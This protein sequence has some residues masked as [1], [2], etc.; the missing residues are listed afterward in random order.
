MKRKIV[1]FI[2][3]GAIVFS[4]ASFTDV[5]HL[6]SDSILALDPTNSEAVIAA[7]VKPLN[8]DSVFTLDA[9]SS[10][11]LVAQIAADVTIQSEAESPITV[12]QSKEIGDIIESSHTS[13]RIS[14]SSF[15]DPVYCKNIKEITSP[16]PVLRLSAPA[17][18]GMTIVSIVHSRSSE[19]N[20]PR[21]EVYRSPSYTTKDHKVTTSLKPG[22]YIWSS[23]VTSATG[24]IIKSDVY[25][26][27][28]I[29]TSAEIQ[30]EE[31]RIDTVATPPTITN[32]LSLPDL[33][34]SGR[35]LYWSFDVIEGVW[36]RISKSLHDAILSG[37]KLT[38][39]DIKTTGNLPTLYAEDGSRYYIFD[40]KT[41][42]WKSSTNPFK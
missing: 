13:D 17:S 26:C 4:T 14:I 35:G 42:T 16:N 32:P 22:R 40:Y 6:S 2:I 31:A 18:G 10:E 23:V 28:D 12:E 38:P 30:D 9:T 27:F 15:V 19:D 8:L 33:L 20:S 11:V 25:Q 36:N 37:T 41:F 39:P 34:T 3:L 24:K 29:G 7:D 21:D 1:K 5:T